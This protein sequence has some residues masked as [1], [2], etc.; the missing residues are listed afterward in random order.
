MKPRRTCAH[1][2]R[3]RRHT[4]SVP[5]NTQARAIH[6]AKPPPP[7]AGMYSRQV[8][9]LKQESQTAYREC[10]C[11]HPRA[12]GRAVSDL[13]AAEIAGLVQGEREEDCRLEL[14]ARGFRLLTNDDVEIATKHLTPT[15]ARGEQAGGREG[16]TGRRTPVT[17]CLET[18]QTS[19]ATRSSAVSASSKALP[20]PN[21]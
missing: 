7:P 11:F 21:L 4:S 18:G 6:G 12:E 14:G 9:R 5:E 17:P 19:S 10:G 13:S 2:Y 8:G 16:D 20:V 15:S 1:L 3:V